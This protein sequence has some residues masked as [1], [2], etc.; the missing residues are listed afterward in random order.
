M[1]IGIITGEYP[2]MQGGVGAYTRILAQQLSTSG[3]EVS[4]FS[5]HPAQSDA[6]SIHQITGKWGI[7]SLRTIQQWAAKNQLD[8]VNLQFQTA[9]YGMSPW[10][11]FLPDALPRVPT[12]TTFHDLRFPYLFPMAGPLRGWIVMHLARRSTGVIVTNHEDSQRVK[13]LTR[14]RLIPIGSNILQALPSDIDTQIWRKKAG[15]SDPDFLMAYFGLINRSKGLET[16]LESL[17]RLRDES[18]PARL[19]IIG[20]VTGSSDP[21]NI[22]YI[23]E[24][25]S[26]ITQYDLSDYIHHTGFLEDDSEVGGFLTASDVVVLPFSD[27]ASY[28]RG[29]LMAAI[30]YGCATITTIPRAHVPAFVHGQ[31]MWLIPRQNADELT[32][33]LRQL[34]TS[35][36][37]GEHLRQGAAELATKFDWQ[38]IANDYLDFF[39]ITIGK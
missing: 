7:G 26:L 11:H 10:I 22:N 28:R 12:V 30:H 4:L 6:L 15:A 23:E 37:I 39:E 36:E 16:L 35:P 31:N 33:A 24:I 34:Y 8:V 29:S 18:I 14:C 27:G 21:T 13:H 3:H 1:R 32:V 2:P 9:A 25:E 19:L 5:A 20:G 17:R 38:H